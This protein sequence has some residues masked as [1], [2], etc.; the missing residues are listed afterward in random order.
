MKNHTN[1]FCLKHSYKN[2][3]GAKPSDFLDFIMK[4]EI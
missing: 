2:L 4:L 1:I 3:I